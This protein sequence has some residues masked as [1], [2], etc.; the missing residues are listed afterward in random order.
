MGGFQYFPPVIKALLISNIGIFLLQVVLNNF[1]INGEGIGGFV[2]DLFALHPLGHGFWPWQLLSFQFMH[3]GLMHLL[4]NMFGLWMF[5]LELEQVWGSKKFLTYYLLCGFGGGAAHLLLA[6]IVPG[7]QA[8][9]LVGASAGIVG[10]LAAFGMMFPDRLIYFYFLIPVKAKYF[11]GIF[12]VIELFSLGRVDN[13]GHLA[14]LGG[15]VVGII[16]MLVTTGGSAL[17]AK[18]KSNGP[19][20]SAFSNPPSNSWQNPPKPKAGGFFNRPGSGRPVE[21]EY[22]DIPGGKQGATQ[23][24]ADVR[25][26]KVITQE[27]IDRILDKIAATGYQNL[28]E[29]EREVL[30]EAARRMDQPR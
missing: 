9:L 5:G 28:T 6:G 30:F 17:R 27:E 7:Q 20:M 25:Q 16:Y 19:G 4:F 12:L 11:V 29:Q 13:V 24:V 18:R 22:H 23:T 3:G 10:L 15:A 2:D 26:A 21:A 1:V 8:A 14:H